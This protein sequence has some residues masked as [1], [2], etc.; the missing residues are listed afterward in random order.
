MLSNAKK[1][2]RKKKHNNIYI[3]LGPLRN[4]CQN[5]IRCPQDL[6]GETPMKEKWERATGD[7]VRGHTVRQVKIP[8]KRKKRR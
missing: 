7:W 6:L 1:I 4:R 2:I 5:G 3:S 8:W